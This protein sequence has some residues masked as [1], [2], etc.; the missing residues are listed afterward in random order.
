MPE[1]KYLTASSLKDFRTCGEKGRLSHIER[2][3]LNRKK[4]STEFGKACHAAVEKFYGSGDHPADTFSL[5]WQDERNIPDIYS[6]K[7]THEGL[8]RTG[9]A[10]MSLFL[11]DH[12]RPMHPVY[13][14]KPWQCV[15]A[16]EVPFF[17]IIDYDGLYGHGDDFSEVIDWKTSPC[18]YPDWKVHLDQQ[19]TSYAYLKAVNQRMPDRVGF[20]VLVKKKREPDIRFLYSR[21]TK[22]HLRDW[23]KLVIQTWR[24]IHDGK[25]QK[26]PGDYCGYC[27]YLPLCLGHDI[28]ESYY[29]VVPVS[30]RFNPEEEDRE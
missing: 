15:V 30:R 21:R 11:Q 4:S 26:E 9:S 16:D 28:P 20:G 24:D 23:E 17:G 14:E 1:I 7:D 10:L 27:D 25:L 19:L 3:R 5:L 8:L 18:R 22:A 29:K 12:E 13:L 6:G 2:I